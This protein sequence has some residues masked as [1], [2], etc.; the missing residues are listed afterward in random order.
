MLI[1]ITGL[2][3]AG[4]TTFAIALS[5]AT[6]AVHLNT[7]RVR[8]ALGLRGQYDAGSK[9]KVYHRLITLL[10]T[11]LRQGETA[12]VDATLYRANIRKP[13]LDLAARL[14]TPIKWIEMRAG[15]QTIRER[16]QTKRPF[17]EADFKV[18][19]HLKTSYEPL[20]FPHLVL[21]SEAGTMD[22]LVKQALDYLEIPAP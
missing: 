7:D 17:S 14:S 10:E 21:H 3:G 5:K 6:G 16:L 13:F 22:E 1:L 20:E 11:H 4:K 2:P 12:I 18:Y 15:E 19:L 9:E 8:A